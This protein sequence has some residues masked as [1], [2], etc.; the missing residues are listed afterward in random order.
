MPRI[1]Y[2]TWK[3]PENPRRITAA[4]RERCCRQFFRLLWLPNHRPSPTRSW[5]IQSASPHFPLQI[6]WQAHPTRNEFHRCCSPPSPDNFLQPVSPPES[7]DSRG[8][9]HQKYLFSVPAA[10]VRSHRL[11]ERY[12]HTQFL[13]HNGSSNPDYAFS[14]KNAPPHYIPETSSESPDGVYMSRKIPV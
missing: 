10:L 7:E 9:S 4:R 12:V 2:C 13:P 14:K 5:R 3:F 6:L 11:P 8:H 1:F